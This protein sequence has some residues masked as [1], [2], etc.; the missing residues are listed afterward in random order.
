MIGNEER[1]DFNY[2]HPKFEQLIKMLNSEKFETKELTAVLYSPIISG[3]TPKNYVYPMKGVPFLGARNIKNGKID[4]S[5]IVYIDDYIHEGMLQSS[6]ITT[7]DILVTMAGAIGRC[8]IYSSS[9]EA[10]I[11]Q[12]VARLKPNLDLINPNYLLYYLNSSIGQLQF[13][14]NRHDVNQPN[15]NTTEMGKIKVI[16]PDK[17]IQNNIINQ[18]SDVEKTIELEKRTQEDDFQKLRNIILLELGLSTPSVKFDWYIHPSVNN[19][20]RL[21]FVWNHP[22]TSSVKQYLEDK[23]AVAL[24]VLIENEVEYGLNASGKDKGKV[25]FV[26]I[27]Q[28]HP[29]GTIHHEEIKYVDDAPL[30]KLLK[31]NDILVCRSRAVG[32][33]ALVA[34]AEN[35]FT[36]GSFILRIR[37]KETTDISPQ[38]VVSFLNSDLGK[39]QFK[40]LQT[41]SEKFAFT[42]KTG[43]GGGN[44]INT[45]SLR[46]IRVILPESKERQTTILERIQQLLKSKQDSDIKLK[47]QIEFQKGLFEKILFS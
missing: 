32:T 47:S 28:V 23:N 6:K 36:F 5:D 21:D 46:Q 17:D 27:E 9:E 29:D 11:S 33:A 37:L 16:R 2:W 44:N 1:L 43:R 30:S 39:I 20:E 25:R 35:G 38:Y 41:G 18:L 45:T 26:N 12:A 15:I 13:E 34:E 7:G 24:G 4:F 14:R 22:M 8:A 40:F 10:N 19:S 3:K 31:P 42:E